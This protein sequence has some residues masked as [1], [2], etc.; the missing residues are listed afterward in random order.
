[1]PGFSS[2]KLNSL[3]FKLKEKGRNVI[4]V[5]AFSTLKEV[6]LNKWPPDLH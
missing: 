3:L 1:M 2:L 4:Y 6:S 5:T